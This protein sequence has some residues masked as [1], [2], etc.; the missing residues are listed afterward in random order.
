MRR[1]FFYKTSGGDS[2]VEEF[3]E[4]LPGKVQQ[5][6]AWV[7]KIVR[8]LPVVNRQFLKKLSGT[9]DIWEIRIDSGSDTFRILGFFDRGDLVILTNGFAK[10][11]EKTPLK[12]IKLAEERK[13]DYE[14]RKDG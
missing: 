12:E 9:K 6:I 4:S 8:E 2:P 11:T 13:S 7:L 1:I 10:K 14:E 5:K 3:I